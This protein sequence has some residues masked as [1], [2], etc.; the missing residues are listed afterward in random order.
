MSALGCTPECG[1]YTLSTPATDAF[2]DSV[3]S[4]ELKLE[5]TAIEACGSEG[6]QG[7][8]A[9]GQGQILFEPTNGKVAAYADL[10]LQ[11]TF[12]SDEAAEGATLRGTSLAGRAFT[13]LGTTHRDE[14]S[15]TEGTLTFHKVGPLLVEDVFDRR[16]VEVS[17]QLTWGGDPGARYVATGRDVMDLY[18]D[19]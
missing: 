5:P 17:W 11:L 7:R 1:R 14:V 4:P 18:V 10:F 19:K 2:Y 16:E 9:P 8:W 3:G 15:L 6:T 13:G 12:N